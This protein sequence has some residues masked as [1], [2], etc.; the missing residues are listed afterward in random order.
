MALI[1]M[2]DALSQIPK[3]GQ[4]LQPVQPVSSILSKNEN[5]FLDALGAAKLKNTAHPVLIQEISLGMLRMG[6]KAD[7]A[8]ATVLS[9]AANELRDAHGELTI[10]ELKLAFEMASRMQLD[11]DPNTYQHFSLL[12]LNKLM[13]AYK[14]WSNQT[15]RQLRP[16]QE[17]S[18]E[19]EKITWSAYIYETKSENQFRADLELGLKNVR[20]E[21]LSMPYFIPYE[22]Y[23][24]LSA[25]GYVDVILDYPRNKKG[26]DLTEID[27]MQLAEMQQYVFDFLVTFKGERLYKPAE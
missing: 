15:Y 1:S 4:S 18:E 16:N 19:K 22:W 3:S 7:K 13:A 24:Q 6:L 21:M 25:D 8:D 9:L 23:R 20:N 27:K 5:A 17:R 11:F 2:V 26:S 12:Y 14:A 10:K